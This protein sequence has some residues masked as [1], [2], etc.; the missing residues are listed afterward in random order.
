[1]ALEK[2]QNGS[3]VSPVDDHFSLHHVAAAA[4][5]LARV[6]LLVHL[7]LFLASDNN[8]RESCYLCTSVLSGPG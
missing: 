4:E 6:D 3:L 2:T 8:A 5:W 7:R 1:M